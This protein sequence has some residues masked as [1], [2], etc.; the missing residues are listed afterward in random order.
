MKRDQK[1]WLASINWAIAV[2]C[3]PGSRQSGRIF[4]GLVRRKYKE[5]SPPLKKEG[6]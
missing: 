5:L 1:L 2:Q 6:V 4:W 3:A